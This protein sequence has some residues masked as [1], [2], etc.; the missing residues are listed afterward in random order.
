MF[1]Q[2]CYIL[3]ELITAA[4]SGHLLLVSCFV[5]TAVIGLPWWSKLPSCN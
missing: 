5:K 1:E 4:L 3:E 2:L